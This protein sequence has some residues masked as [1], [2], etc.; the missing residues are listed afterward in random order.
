MRTRLVRLTM[1]AGLFALT[2]CQSEASRIEQL[3]KDLMLANS[4][5][6]QPFV[7]PLEQGYGYAPGYQPQQGRM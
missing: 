4:A 7:T 2:G 6:P 3:R 1:L 5:Y